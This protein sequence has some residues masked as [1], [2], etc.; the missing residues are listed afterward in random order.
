MYHPD[1]HPDPKHKEKA[2]IM[3]N[4]VKRAYEGTNYK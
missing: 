1:K 2:E 3:F 4:K